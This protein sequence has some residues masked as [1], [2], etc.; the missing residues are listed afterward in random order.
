LVFLSVSGEILYRAIARESQSK[1]KTD[2]FYLI[3]AKNHKAK[4]ASEQSNSYQY[5]ASEAVYLSIKTN[6]QASWQRKNKTSKRGQKGL[7]K[8]KAKEKGE[9]KG[10]KGTK[11]GQSKG[12]A[13]KQ[14]AK[15][16]KNFKKLKAKP[17]KVTQKGKGKEDQRD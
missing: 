7:E 10:S 11:Q 17:T 15:K 5:R 12:K 16:P 9:S 4:L 3:T 6:R 2:L 13:K 14:R 8:G 1:V